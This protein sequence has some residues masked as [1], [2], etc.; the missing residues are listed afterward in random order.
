MDVRI[1]SVAVAA[2]VVDCHEARARLDEPPGHQARLAEE[3]AAVAVTER[4]RLPFEVEGVARPRT[5]DEAEGAL[6]EP[7]EFE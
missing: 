2:V 3:M 1:P 4:R 5:R 7:V 6:A